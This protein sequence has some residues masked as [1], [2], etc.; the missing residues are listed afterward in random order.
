MNM[1]FADILKKLREKKGLSQN[2]IAKRI[3]VTRATIS[4]WENGNRLPD[5]AM[6]TRL[7]E[8][9]GV[10]VNVLFHAAAQS[11]ENLIVIMVDDN[12]V[13]L[14]GGLPIIKWASCSSRSR[15]MA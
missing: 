15:P 7:S 9:L 8:V 10:D 1:L 6:I 2:E 3:Y 13:I 12:K 5:A 14:N 4:R 11:D